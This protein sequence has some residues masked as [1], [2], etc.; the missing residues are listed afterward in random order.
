VLGPPA[1][2]RHSRRERCGSRATRVA[3]FRNPGSSAS[4]PESFPLAQLELR[5]GQIISG[6]PGAPLRE[7]TGHTFKEPAVSPAMQPAWA[8]IVIHRAR[9]C[10]RE[11]DFHVRS[12]DVERGSVG[13]AWMTSVALAWRHTLRL[14]G[15]QR[16]RLVFGVEREKTHATGDDAS[17][18]P[19]IAYS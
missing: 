8:L 1:T 11:I 6:R 14:N 16:A 17:V 4:T 10:S 19:G 13:L 18:R 7:Q 3:V 12:P 15:V 2:E 5:F 9:N